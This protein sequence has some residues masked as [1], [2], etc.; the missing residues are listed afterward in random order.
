MNNVGVKHERTAK[1]AQ[2]NHL[3]DTNDAAT[4]CAIEQHGG[5]ESQHVDRRSVFG[6]NA[7]DWAKSEKRLLA[8]ISNIGAVC[9]Y[10]SWAGYFSGDAFHGSKIC[11]RE[12]L[13]VLSDVR[14]T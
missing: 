10:F 12:Q 8:S 1:M 7:F 11:E 6:F 3:F 13:A 4:S 9:A 2:R 5:S 14:A